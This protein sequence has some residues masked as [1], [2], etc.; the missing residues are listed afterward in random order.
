M[1]PCA[2]LAV[3]TE[4][5]LPKDEA[6]PLKPCFPF[7]GSVVHPAV[8]PFPFLNSCRVH[9]DVQHRNLIARLAFRPMVFFYYLSFVSITRLFF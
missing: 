3:V 9:S 6:F 7:K 1:D 2:P 4:L 5:L 8:T